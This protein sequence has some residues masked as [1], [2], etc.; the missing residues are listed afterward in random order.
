MGLLVAGLVLL[1][2]G[3]MRAL[4]PGDVRPLP[5]ST[6]S[7]DRST[8]VSEHGAG[9]GSATPAR[10]SSTAGEGS[11]SEEAR[12]ALPEDPAARTEAAEAEWAKAYAGVSPAQ[13][14][15]EA[16]AILDHLIEETKDE[17]ERR[18]DGGRYE[19]IAS[20]GV[21]RMDPDRDFIAGLE[22]VRIT[23][24][25]DVR[26]VVLPPDEFPELYQLGRKAIWL[27]GSAHQLRLED[28]VLYEQRP[29]QPSP[30]R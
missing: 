18:F 30:R 19:R 15:E 5:V 20:D 24:E 21:Y 11:A 1:A 17:I 27:Q 13:L 7:S 12:V 22:Q 9:G 14:E 26:S 8:S 16:T 29:S 3:R 23:S 10:E 28:P 4:E 6:T 2:I 25:G